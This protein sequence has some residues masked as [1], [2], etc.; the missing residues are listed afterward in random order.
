MN[1]ATL[2]VGLRSLK[3]DLASWQARAARIACLL[4]DYEIDVV[5]F[6]E[7]FAVQWESASDWLRSLMKEAGLPEADFSKSNILRQALPSFHIA[8]ELI[9]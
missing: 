5:L 6:Q 1:I 2:N 4:D 8:E 7:L 3:A 9:H